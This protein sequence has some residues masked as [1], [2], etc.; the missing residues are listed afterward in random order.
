MAVSALVISHSVYA[1]EIQCEYGKESTCPEGQFCINSEKGRA[2]CKPPALATRY[3]QR[4]Y[5]VK[6]LACKA[7]LM[8]L[9]KIIV[10]RESDVHSGPVWL[11]QCY[12]LLF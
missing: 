11:T 7:K 9:H 12:S 3:A 2:I 6:G 4:F 8:S 10:D 5:H 1:S